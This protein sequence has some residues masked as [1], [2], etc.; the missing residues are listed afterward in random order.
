M[1]IFKDC[2]FIIAYK[3]QKCFHVR[4][5]LFG[6]CEFFFV[7][8]LAFN[9]PASRMT[10]REHV[11]GIGSGLVVRFEV[12]LFSSRDTV[13]KLLVFGEIFSR[14]AKYYGH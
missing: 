2:F 12:L 13:Q 7:N 8:A 14:S 5:R 11:A 10:T 6:I 4:N 9:S 3:I 1:L